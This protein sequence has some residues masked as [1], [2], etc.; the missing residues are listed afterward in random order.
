MAVISYNSKNCSEC[1]KEKQLSEFGK[2]KQSKGGYYSKCK[3]CQKEWYNNN[4]IVLKEKR[5]VYIEKNKNKIA[6]KTKAYYE[7]NKDKIIEYGKEYS[8]E[9]YKNNKDKVKKKQ[10][11]YRENN[12][13]KYNAYH[14]KLRDTNPLHKMSMNIRN[15]T[16][17]AF[18]RGNWNKDSSNLKMLG[19]DYTTAFNHLEKQFTSGMNWDNYGEWH[20]D[21][22]KPL[23]SANTKEELK[24]LCLYTNLQPL[25]AI[26]NL[27]KGGKYIKPKQNPKQKLKVNPN[28]PNPFDKVSHLE[29]LLRKKESLRANY[30]ERA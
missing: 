6:E 27:I 21:H 29:E 16:R 5:A 30:T 19:C 3:K 8:L 22:I 1:N 18:N 11:N 28:K 12:K 7:T 2:H 23:I 24:K 26:D 13:Q 20:I 10:K 25:W 17:K 9:W 14:K 15:R 4:K